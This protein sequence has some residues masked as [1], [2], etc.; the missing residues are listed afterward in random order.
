ME[1][2]HPPLNLKN[3]GEAPA[4]R[5]DLKKSDIRYMIVLVISRND[6][7]LKNLI[8][9]A[10]NQLPIDVE[11]TALK[12]RRRVFFELISPREFGQCDVRH[13]DSQYD[14]SSSTG[15]CEVPQGPF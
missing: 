14:Q 15:R 13:G 10:F 7:Q 3:I 4:A 2:D 5:F 8:F 12:I 9:S 6:V 11:P 1:I